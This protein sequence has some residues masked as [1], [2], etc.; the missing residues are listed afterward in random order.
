M[1][2]LPVLSGIVKIYDALD[3]DQKDFLIFFCKKLNRL[4][5]RRNI[6]K[7]VK[8]TTSG[9]FQSDALMLK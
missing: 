9:K 7:S 4:R 5:E 3:C 1:D 8:M 2:A 6:K